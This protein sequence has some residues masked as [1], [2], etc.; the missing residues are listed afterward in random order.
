VARLHEV[1]QAALEAGVALEAID[2][3]SAG[4]AIT[5]LRDSGPETLEERRREAERV[6]ESLAAGGEEAS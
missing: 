2:L 6:V 5:N 1:G 4:R 3:A